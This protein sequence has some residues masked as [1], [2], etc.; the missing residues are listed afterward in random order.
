MVK[1]KS[2]EKVLVDK[3]AN[4]PPPCPGEDTRTA[5]NPTMVDVSYVDD[6]GDDAMVQP[7]DDGDEDWT[8]NKSMKS[9]KPPVAG[10]RTSSRLRRSTVS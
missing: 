5:P 8:P 1:R 4:T 9:A 2:C 10:Q 7:K 6:G 3:D